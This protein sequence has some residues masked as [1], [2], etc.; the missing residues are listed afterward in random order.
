MTLSVC[1]IV[2]DEQ[3][4]LGRCLN[5]IFKSRLISVS[6]RGVQQIRRVKIGVLFKF[7]YLFAVFVRNY[8]V[9][10]QP[11]NGKYTKSKLPA[12]YTLTNVQNFITAVNFFL[13][14]CIL[15]APPFL[16]TF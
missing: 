4:V 14:E 16:K 6:R 13:T 15:K 5:L 9:R 2:K 12:E 8:V 1:L 7:F 10:V 11:H 3:E